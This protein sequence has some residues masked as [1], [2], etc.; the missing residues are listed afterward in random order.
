MINVGFYYKVK[1]GYE[2]EFE[3]KFKDVVEYLKTFP[4]FKDAKLYKN[5]DNPS[6][7]LIYSEWEDLDSFRRFT[8]SMAYKETIKY[9]KSIIE[10]RPKHKIFQE[11]NM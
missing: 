4:G 6:E 7:Y 11:V 9:G 8:A 3:K 10:D 2:E 5:V 1:K